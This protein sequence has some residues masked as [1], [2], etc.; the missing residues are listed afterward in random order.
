MKN[1]WIIP[2]LLLLTSFVALSFTNAKAETL[3]ALIP[4]AT[5]AELEPILAA[6]DNL[7]ERNA[8][9]DTAVI[10]AAREGRIDILEQ[11]VQHG[12]N[13]NALDLK[14]RDVLNIAVTTRN[15]DL[16]RVA[17]KLGA[18]ATMV[19]S[20]YDGGAIIYASAKGAT[21]IV[22][23][24][25]EAGAPV[26]RVNNLGWTA[27]L[28]V[29]ILGSDT[30]PYH[31]IAMQLIAAGADKSITDNDGKSPFDHARAKGYTELAKLLAF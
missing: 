18:D 20:V 11:L 17:L 21:D 3:P 6:H 22:K 28:E 29:A 30:K 4:Q 25:L 14:K 2:S 9:G 8:A 10:V 31:D 7:E 15:P 5:L 13:I 1:Q 19:T 23:M 16:A 24:L 27:L 26:N 12:A